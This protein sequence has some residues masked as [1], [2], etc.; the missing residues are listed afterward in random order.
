MESELQELLENIYNFRI[1]VKFLDFRKYEI[2]C[3][4]KL[5]EFCIPI[6]YDGK[7]TLESNIQNAI[8]KIDKEI[9]KYYKKKGD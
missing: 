4:T 1:D 9:L 2:Y 3:K 6:L 8:H 5:F 7:F